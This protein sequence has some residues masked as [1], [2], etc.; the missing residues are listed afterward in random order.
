MTAILVYEHVTQKHE[1]PSPVLVASYLA[2]IS[3]SYNFLAIYFTIPIIGLIPSVIAGLSLNLVPFIIGLIYVGLKAGSMPGETAGLD[4]AVV[5]LLVCGHVP[6]LLMVAF[7][8]WFV[9]VRIYKA[10]LETYVPGWAP[11]LTDPWLKR[12]L[13]AMEAVMR[14]V[15]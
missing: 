5:G 2:I 14:L 1:M 9:N 15:R 11:D 13:G 4:K 3:H 12:V 10:W 6:Q 8:R 7:V